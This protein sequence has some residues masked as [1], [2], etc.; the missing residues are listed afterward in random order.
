MFC[1]VKSLAR[2]QHSRK[3]GLR[4]LFTIAKNKKR[5]INHT[6]QNVKKTCSARKSG[7]RVIDQASKSNVV[8]VEVGMGNLA[9]YMARAGWFRHY[10]HNRKV[11]CSNSIF[12]S[13]IFR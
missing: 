7:R 6:K 4:F 1:I 9:F 5:L 2:Q 12:Y 11:P 3:Y 8:Y 10:A 13:A